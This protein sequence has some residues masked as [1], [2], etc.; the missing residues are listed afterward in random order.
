MREKIGT[1]DL[2]RDLTPISTKSSITRHLKVHEY[3][4]EDWTTSW[5]CSLTAL[6]ALRTFFALHLAFCLLL[7]IWIKFE[8]GKMKWPMLPFYFTY[9]SNIFTA[10]YFA[11]GA[12]WGWRARMLGGSHV[13]ARRMYAKHRP[14]ALYA[15]H[16]L[17]SASFTFHMMTTG[18]YWLLLHKYFKVEGFLGFYCALGTHGLPLAMIIT[19][20]FLNNRFLLALA[21]FLPVLVFLLGYWVWALCASWLNKSTSE[22]T[23]GWPYK[24]LDPSNP[25]ALLNYSMIFAGVAVCFLIAWSMHVLKRRIFHKDA[26]SEEAKE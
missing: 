9:I 17:Y 14:W 10:C 8:A 26:R 6:A 7:D 21:E 4:L 5:C 20:F 16:F 13:Y 19:D 3:E 25:Q 24:I 22:K 18:M 1:P 23:N 2:E 15:M 12:W 11:L